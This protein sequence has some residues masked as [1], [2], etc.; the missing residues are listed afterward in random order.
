MPN[1]PSDPRWAAIHAAAAAEKLAAVAASVV[2]PAPV[3]VDPAPVVV[4]VEAPV[5]VATAVE[6][7]GVLHEVEVA[8]M[9]LVHKIEGK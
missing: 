8:L 1:D 6:P 4:H 7:T 2:E 9:G 3:V 5:V